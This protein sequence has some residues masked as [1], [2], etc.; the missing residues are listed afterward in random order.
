MLELLGGDSE[1]VSERNMMQYLGVVEQR[2][3]ELLTQYC[4]LAD[5]SAPSSAGER[6]AAVLSG[7]AGA[8]AP[9]R[10]VIEPPSVAGGGV[11]TSGAVPALP[12][13]AGSHRADEEEQVHEGGLGA[14]LNSERPLSRGSLAARAARAVA[15]RGEAAVKVKAVR[16][17]AAS[18][19]GGQQRRL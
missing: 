10:Y 19:T 12:A 13:S 4:M 16:A 15:A 14:A 3:N 2:T 9:L 6:A 8:Q 17:Q 7:A 1:G 18:S 11:G 5:D